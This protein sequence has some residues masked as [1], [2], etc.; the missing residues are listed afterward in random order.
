[1]GAITRVRFDAEGRD[2]EDVRA[3]LDDATELLRPTQMFTELVQVGS[4]AG[5]GGPSPATAAGVAIGG[6]RD[7]DGQLPDTEFVEEV[8]ESKIRDDGAIYYTGRR[9]LQVVPRPLE[10]R[11]ADDDLRQPMR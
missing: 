8:Y 10:L 5:A 4:N 9:V 11:R 2:L 3:A 7:E 6:L 1:M